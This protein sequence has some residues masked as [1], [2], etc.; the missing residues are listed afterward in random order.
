MYTNNEE[1]ITDYSLYALN[2]KMGYDLEIA[3]YVK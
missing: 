3:T 1:E 2:K